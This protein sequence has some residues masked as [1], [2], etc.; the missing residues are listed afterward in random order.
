M[1]N[2]INYFKQ[3]NKEYK[4]F[5]IVLSRFSELKSIKNASFDTDFIYKSKEIEKVLEENHYFELFQK[6]NNSKSLLNIKI[7]LLKNTRSD[8]YIKAGSSLFLK[9]NK[10][11]L[12]STFKKILNSNGT[13]ILFDFH[14]LRVQTLM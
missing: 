1:T 13:I 10:N 14:F 8:N 3:F 11:S 7:F 5:I 12:L 6:S 2:N 4:E 9:L